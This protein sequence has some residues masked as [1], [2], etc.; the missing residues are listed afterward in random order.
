MPKTGDEMENGSTKNDIVELG[1]ETRFQSGEEAA[2]KGRLG[3]I[4][5]GE[6]RRAKRD[7]RQA[8]QKLLNMSARGK[9]LENLKELGYGEDDEGIKNIDVV[10]A[11]LLVQ[12]AS[13]NLDASARLLKIAG[14]DY[15][16][17]RLERE[18]LNADRRK[19]QESAARLEAMGEGRLG[20]VSSSYTDG[21]DDSSVEDVFIYLPDNGRDTHLQ[22]PVPK[23]ENERDGA[24]DTE[25]TSVGT[26]GTEQPEL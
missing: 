14:Y 18:S 13:G 15:E 8:A 4:K 10:V 6:T 22:K 12:A 2:E 24:A 20:R 19:D 9:M 7:A 1:K 26:G 23:K 17:N 5:S 3:G 16:E 11:R 21:D 25:E